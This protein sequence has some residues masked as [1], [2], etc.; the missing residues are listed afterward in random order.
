LHP[1][2]SQASGI[3]GSDMSWGVREFP[4]VFH[5]MVSGGG[6]TDCCK[7]AGLLPDQSLEVGALNALKK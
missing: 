4:S 3:G 7:W 1:N 6:R 2:S 5:P